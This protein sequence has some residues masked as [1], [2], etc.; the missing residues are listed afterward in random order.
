MSESLHSLF[1]AAADAACMRDSQSQSQSQAV[2][3]D[4]VARVRE[5]AQLPARCDTCGTRKSEG[6]S[7]HVADVDYSTFRDAT[8]YQPMQSAHVP[9]SSGKYR[10]M[11]VDGDVR[12]G[13]HTKTG[14][15]RRYKRQ[16]DNPMKYANDHPYLIDRWLRTYGSNVGLR[17]LQVHRMHVASGASSNRKDR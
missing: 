6:C 9:A 8:P 10:T 4:H 13:D 15:H 5:L 11:S 16:A 3:N 1:I 14:G 7:C 2:T 12:I 17:A